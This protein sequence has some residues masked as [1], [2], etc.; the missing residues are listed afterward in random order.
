MKKLFCILILVSIYGNNIFAQTKPVDTDG[1]GYYNIST[2]DEL[3]WV[4]ENAEARN[5][6]FEL[7]NDIDASDTRNWNDGKGWEPISEWDNYSKVFVF[8]GNGFNIDSLYINRPNENLVGFF[9]NLINAEV[10]NLNLTNCQISGSNIVGSIAAE[11][12]YEGKILNCFASGSVKGNN[13]VGGIIGNSSAYVINCRFLGKVSGNSNIGGIAGQSESFQNCSVEGIVEGNENVGGIAGTNNSNIFD[14]S[15]NA[16]V[17][18]D[19]NVGGICGN[20][21]FSSIFNNYNLKKI[22]GNTN[23]GGLVGLYESGLMLNSYNIASIEGNENVGGLI[24]NSISSLAIN[25]FNAGLVEGDIATGGLIGLNN[26]VDLVLNSVWDEESSNQQSSAGGL[27]KST[28]EMKNKDTY[29]D[30]GW[31]FD[32]IW[33]I[34]LNYPYID[35]DENFKPKDTDDN[36]YFNITELSELRWLSESGRALDEKFE[37]DND[38][39]AEQSRYWNGGVG[40]IPIQTFTGIFNGNDFAL[41]NIF[42]ELPI[43]RP[44]GVFKYLIGANIHN[45][46][47]EDCNISGIYEIGGLCGLSYKSDITECYS[48]GNIKGKYVLGGIV[49]SS[50]SDEINKCFS[51]CNIDYIQ[52]DEFEFEYELSHCAGGFVGSAD[53]KIYNCYARGYV[54]GNELSHF[55]G[56]FVGNADDNS[57]IYNCYSTGNVI[58]SEYSG[59]FGGSVSYVFAD[60]CFFD[61]ETCEN[62]YYDST[63]AKTTAEMKT[64]STFTDAGWDFEEIWNIDGVTNDGYP[65]FKKK[66]S[67]VEVDK[68]DQAQSN[69]LIYPNPAKDKINIKLLNQEIIKSI[70][71]RDMKSNLMF[72]LHENLIIDIDIDISELT[73]GTYFIT[74]I[75]ANSKHTEKFVII[76]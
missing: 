28:N 64:K 9:G 4:S 51:I 50:T 31:N 29:L 76:K 45:L 68:K 63:F 47:I 34:D 52:S 11:I 3:R 32:F 42:I 22:N 60:Y 35:I 61:S 66:T 30:L 75:T 72:D 70:E 67:T 57:E 13:V 44:A 62:Y 14:C 46:G 40:F 59:G 73:T 27:N 69:I 21:H 12:Y 17:Y 15:N 39:D 38:I 55:V 1:D 20:S 41:R 49:G 7:D 53:S 23:V 71:I 56:G 43:M 36:G 48:T 74:I 24:G 5:M 54:N 18:G 19:I 37:L 10:K 58:G 2:L 16:D 65:F 26:R 25:C 8:D 6:N 33:K